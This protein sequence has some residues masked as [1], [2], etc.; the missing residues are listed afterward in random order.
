[1]KTLRQVRKDFSKKLPYIFLTFH[2]I[3]HSANINILYAYV[4]VTG[5]FCGMTYFII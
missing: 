4:Y 1:M 2:I 3:N 5:I